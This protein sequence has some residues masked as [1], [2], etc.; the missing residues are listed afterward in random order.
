M[1]AYLTQ[2]SACRIIIPTAYRED[3]LLPLKTLS[4]NADPIPYLHSMTRAQAWSA[5]FDYSDFKNILRQMA[6]C[7]AFEEDITQHKLLH[8]HEIRNLVD[9]SAANSQF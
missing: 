3:Y 8:P 1:N 9:N 6:A 4:R 5:E 2:S 7:Y